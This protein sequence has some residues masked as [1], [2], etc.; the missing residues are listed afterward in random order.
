MHN[1]IKNVIKNYD[2]IIIIRNHKN[3]AI[4]YYDIENQK[5]ANMVDLSRKICHNQ[6]F[7]LFN[8]IGGGL[9]VAVTVLASYWLGNVIPDIGD[10]ILPITAIILICALTPAFY[11]LIRSQRSNRRRV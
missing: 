6:R 7:A 8:I 10:Y 1:R 2:R 11:R 3:N 5:S 9:W 4:T